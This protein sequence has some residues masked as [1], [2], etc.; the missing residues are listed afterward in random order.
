MPDGYGLVKI[1]KNRPICA[2]TRRD[3]SV[4]YA[5]DKM[6]VGHS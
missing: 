1:R 2:A 5:I 3:R 4:L 6:A